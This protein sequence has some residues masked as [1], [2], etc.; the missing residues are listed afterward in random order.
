[1]A[2]KVCERLLPP[3]QGDAF[4]P[5]A[6]Q[7]RAQEV[8]GHADFQAA[9][10]AAVD[11]FIRERS[12]PAA[13]QD[14]PPVQDGHP[15]MPG[16]VSP[17]V[18]LDSIEVRNFKSIDRLALEFPRLEANADENAAPTEEDAP[19][20]PGQEPP[21]QPWLMV[22]GENGVGKSSLLQAIA[23]ALMPDALRDALGRPSSWLRQHDGVKAASGHVRLGFSDGSVRTLEFRR[24]VAKFVVTGQVPDTL[25][26]LAYGSTRL[27]PSRSRRPAP[28]QAVSVRNLFDH[29][30]PLAST[31]RY[32]CDA[33]GLP[34]PLFQILAGSLKSLL[35]IPEEAELQR[36]PPG[37]PT[38]LAATVGGRTLTLG[39]LS[40]GYKSMLALA[41]DIMFHL[42]RSSFD[43]ESARGLVM[44]DELELHLHPR[45]KVAIVQRLRELFPNVRFI[46][47]THDPLCVQ[48]LRSGELQIM[49]VDPLTRGVMADSIDVPRGARA[50][51]VLTGPWFGVASTIDAQ[52]QAL[53]DEHS[54]LLALPAR[55]PAQQLRYT[56]LDAL[57]ARRLGNQGT[58]R[59]QRMALAVAAALGQDRPQSQLDLIVQQR[60]GR[61]LDGD[62]GQRGGRSGA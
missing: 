56:Q 26:V 37:K 31:E 58:T 21:G 16:D 61:L 53:M 47:T 46:A 28:P 27:L 55:S 51:D 3:T 62:A 42:T 52:T 19:D 1:M 22:L 18:W 32:L 17:P 41:M 20:E 24:G 23:L 11:H 49:S 5:A 2:L 60:L 50:D 14:Q 9:V 30:H 36:R 13:A 33:Q 38:H 40:D 59:A 12:G 8:L 48:G 6:F 39:Q 35:P 57:L 25:A 43:M 54:K 7:E 15:A 29:R 45:W 44:I 4:E 10:R 34:D